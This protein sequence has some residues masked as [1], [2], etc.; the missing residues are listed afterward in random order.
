MMSLK[1]DL[2]TFKRSTGS[3]IHA[4]PEKIAFA[5]EDSGK[6]A[7]NYEDYE[8]LCADLRRKIHFQD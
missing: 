6:F 7:A 3:D 1:H 4:D 2:L 5:L 8:L